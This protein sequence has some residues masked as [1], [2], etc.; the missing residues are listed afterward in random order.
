MSTV[1]LG[2]ERGGDHVDEGDAHL[3]TLNDAHLSFALDGRKLGGRFVLR[4]STTGPG[5][6]S[7]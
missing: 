3:L 4:T 1:M 6:W 5:C 7:R 2:G